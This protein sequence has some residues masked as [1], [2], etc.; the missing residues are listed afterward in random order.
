MNFFFIIIITVSLKFYKTLNGQRIILNYHTMYEVE[1]GP[2]GLFYHDYDLKSQ[3]E[4]INFPFEPKYMG[5]C[6]KSDIHF[7]HSNCS[8]L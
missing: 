4:K 6:E 8:I 3:R 2:M 1:Y 5:T 7:V